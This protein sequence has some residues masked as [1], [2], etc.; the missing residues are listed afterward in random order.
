MGVGEVLAIILQHG[1]P[2]GFQHVNN[3]LNRKHAEK[4]REIG[5]DDLKRKQQILSKHHSDPV[6]HHKMHI[7]DEIPEVPQFQF[8][9]NEGIDELGN[10]MWSTY[11]D[12]SLQL[13]DNATTSQVKVFLRKVERSA[14]NHPCL[15]CKENITKHLKN[16]K[17][18]GSTK[19]DAVRK[20]YELHN[21]VNKDLGKKIYS[22]QEFK[23]QYQYDIQ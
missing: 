14:R 17:L 21:K 16:F 9:G 2:I 6:E 13:P 11:H 7:N 23:N 18:I 20:I 1:V 12:L 4:I 8:E 15:E 3:H 22:L 5:I 10:R 19:K